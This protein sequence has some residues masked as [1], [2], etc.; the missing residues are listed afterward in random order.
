MLMKKSLGVETG[1]ASS[2][3]DTD[4]PDCFIFITFHYFI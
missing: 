3:H 4:V 2:E 1:T